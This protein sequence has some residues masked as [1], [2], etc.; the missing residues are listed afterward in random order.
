V[1]ATAVGPCA[2][3]WSEHGI[4][5]LQLP[6]ASAAATAERLLRG[7]PGAQRRAPPASVERAIEA[8]RALLAGAAQDLT[9]VELD[10]RH[11]TPFEREVYGAARA[12]A[13]GVTCTYGEL[14]ARIGRPGAAR[15]VGGAM[16]R[17]PFP[18]IV[19]CHR[20]LAAGGRVG[21]FSAPGGVQ[22]KRRLLQ[23]EGLAGLRR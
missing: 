14:A 2:I 6:S 7:C 20:V 16:G 3:A 22:T 12:L 4:R 23:I 1:F 17:N 11:L 10:W 18:L 21:G 19:P 8:I 5:A 9:A 15:A 13:P